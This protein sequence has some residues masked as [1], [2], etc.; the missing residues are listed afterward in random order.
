MQVTAYPAIESTYPAIPHMYICW[1]EYTGVIHGRGCWRRVTTFRVHTWSCI[2][3]HC[4]GRPH[5]CS[6]LA[7]VAGLLTA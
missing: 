7:F 3:G 6:R 5:V 1:R 4:N 2:P